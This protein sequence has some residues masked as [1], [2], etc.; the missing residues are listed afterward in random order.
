M[1]SIA[2][3]KARVGNGGTARLGNGGR[4]SPRRPQKLVY[5]HGGWSGMYGN[6][7][8]LLLATSCASYWGRRPLG[9]ARP[10]IGRLTAVGYKYLWIQVLRDVITPRAKLT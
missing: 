5:V 10:P 7:V 9:S 6:V 2:A 8:C 3:L 4:P 1:I